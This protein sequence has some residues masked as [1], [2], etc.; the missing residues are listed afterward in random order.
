MRKVLVVLFAAVISVALS[1]CHEQKSALSTG[2]KASQPKTNS[3]PTPSLDPQKVNFYTMN[4]LFD[5]AKITI[6]NVQG[7]VVSL[8]LPALQMTNH[9]CDACSSQLYADVTSNI[10]PGFAQGPYTIHVHF[11]NGTVSKYSVPELG[12]VDNVE[13]PVYFYALVSESDNHNLR[14]ALY[15]NGIEQ[16]YF[17]DE[18]HD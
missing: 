5:R 16:E 12:K 4:S 6:K 18:S 15:L 8:Q 3:E 9:G 17:N 10:P 13:Y 7:K 11:R 14:P 2:T 1:G